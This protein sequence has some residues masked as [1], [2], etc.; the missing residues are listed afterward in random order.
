M[1]IPNDIYFNEKTKRIVLLT[2]PN[3]SGKSVCLKQVALICYMAQ[4]GSFV[5]AR[6]STIGILDKIFTRIKSQET[7][8][9]AQSTF[10]IDLLQTSS[11]LKNATSKSLVLLDEFGKGSFE[12]FFFFFF[13]N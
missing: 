3:F 1:F 12:T 10:M 6:E 7:V 4:I 2:G 13:L 11:S 9:K 5:P 8:S